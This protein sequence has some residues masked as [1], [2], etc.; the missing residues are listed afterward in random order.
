MADKTKIKTPAN[1]ETLAPAIGV[2]DGLRV[3][4]DWV[5]AHDAAIAGLAHLGPRLCCGLGVGCAVNSRERD[6]G[7]FSNNAAEGN[8]ALVIARPACRDN[9]EGLCV[10]PVVVVAG[11]GPTVSASASSYAREIAS[12]DSRANSIDGGLGFSRVHG[13]AAQAKTGTRLRVADSVGMACDT[14]EAVSSHGLNLFWPALKE[15]LKKDLWVLQL[16]IGG[17]A[18]RKPVLYTLD[19]V[20]ELFSHGVDPAFGLNELRVLLQINDFFV[21]HGAI[22]HHVC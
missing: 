11:C 3:S 12:A 1:R 19:A 7:N 20:V 15:V 6:G 5:S 8:A 16:Y 4:G 18:A 13:K 21:C 17:D 9:I 2:P 14:G 22:K 10:V